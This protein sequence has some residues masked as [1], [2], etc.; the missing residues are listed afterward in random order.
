MEKKLNGI[1]L[2]DLIAEN[3][4]L[5]GS[6]LNDGKADALLDGLLDA[7]ASSSLE[8]L[9][10]G[11]IESLRSASYRAD[12]ASDAYFAAAVRF[13]DEQRQEEALFLYRLSFYLAPNPKAI[14]N[15]AVIYADSGREAD[16]CAVLREGLALFPDDE[17]IR[18][19]YRALH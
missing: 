9:R 6:E 8:Q 19:N 2:K 7:T 12:R 15:M 3:L 16:A 13:D 1:S 17:T 14:N 4:R 11:V 5:A 18:E 10:L